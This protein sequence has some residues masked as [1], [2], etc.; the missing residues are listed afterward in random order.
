MQKGKAFPRDGHSFWLPISVENYRSLPIKAALCASLSGQQSRFGKAKNSRQVRQSL[1]FFPSPR[2]RD[3]KGDRQRNR[4]SRNRAHCARKFA[5]LHKQ[6]SRRAN[7]GR[8]MQYTTCQG[9]TLGT[10]E[11]KQDKCRLNRYDNFE[12]FQRINSVK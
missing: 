10:P 4:H 3:P 5:Y 8:L 12:N 11:A 9:R 6:P 2:S 1:C 7:R